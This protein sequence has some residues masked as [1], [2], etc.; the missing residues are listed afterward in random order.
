M[1]SPR[2]RTS[3]LRG[4]IARYLALKTSLGRRY[5]AER[6]VLELLEAFLHADGGRTADLTLDRF[7]RWTQTL[8]HLMPTVRRNRLRIVR[9]LC[10]YRRRSEPGCFVPDQADFP[11]PHQ[12][13]APHIFTPGE[14]A[15]LL[16]ATRT[17]AATSESPLRPQVFRLAL[18]LL[19]TTG[20][21]RGELLRLTVG[22]YDP[23]DRVL[24]IRAS[25]FHK[26]RAIPLSPD[27]GR[28]V[29]RYLRTRRRHRLPMAADTPLVA[30]GTTTLHPYTGVGFGDPVRRLLRDT[31][32][33]TATGQLPRLH[34]IRHGFAVNA[35]LRWYR[36]GLDVQTKLPLL[37]TYMG[38]VSIV[39]THYYLAFVEPLRAAASA[40]FAR[41]CGALI[42]PR[43]PTPGRRS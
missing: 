30:H 43:A 24:L 41:H 35:L 8:Q 18:V 5:A 15:R 3:G 33:V 37:A 36:Q 26:S 13:R 2:A 31:G 27:A 38:H 17:L 21:R 7:S 34:D 28:E 22:D 9:N 11:A 12:V 14:I 29:E 19:Y 4:V 40:R 10:L 39:S 23:H 32:I 20:L 1:N 6:R 16:Q 42:S 25:K